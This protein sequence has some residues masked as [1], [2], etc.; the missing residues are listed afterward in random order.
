[1]LQAQPTLQTVL[2]MVYSLPYND[3]KQLVNRVHYNLAL[4]EKEPLIDLDWKS[5]PTYSVDDAFEMAYK[6]L[7][8]LYGLNDIREAK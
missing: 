7:G 1:M 5:K 2:N 4:A 8:L 6:H 3:Q